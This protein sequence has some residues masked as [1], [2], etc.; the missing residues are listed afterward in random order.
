[1]NVDI[2][3]IENK[4]YCL[5]K[6]LEIEGNK[7]LYLMNEKDRKDII[8]RKKIKENNEEFLIGLENEKEFEKVMEE[9]YKRG[10]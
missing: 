3:K 4:E 7:Y 6:E 10:Q 9:Y 8:I 1:M 2:I 5:L